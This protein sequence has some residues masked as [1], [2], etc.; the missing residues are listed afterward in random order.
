MKKVLTIFLPPLVIATAIFFL[1]QF[2][3]FGPSDKGA[4]QVTATPDSEVYLNGRDIGQT[5]LCKCPNANATGKDSTKDL[6]QAGDYTIKLVPKD[7]S[8]PEYV[9]TITIRKSLLTVVDRKFAEGAKSEGSVISLLP[10]AD[11]K[12]SEILVTTFPDKTDIFL[13]DLKDGTSPLLIKD[14]TPEKHE[15]RVRKTGYKE[16]V[17]PLLSTN[18]YRLLAT[19]YLGVDDNAP[20]PTPAASTSASLTPTPPPG[21]PLVTILQTPTGF[22][23]VREDATLDSAEIGRVNPGDKLPLVD[24]VTGWYKIH[25]PTGQE[26]WISSQ[27]A[28][29][30]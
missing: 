30:Q 21:T 10:L 18:G 26:G 9:D 11:T 2:F 3:I 6:L 8:L 29:K 19:I 7:K 17:I 24:E 5:P 1:F 25:L 13:D 28:S 27:Y 4:L 22:L 16:K 15:L 14:V 23:R 20:T 12:K